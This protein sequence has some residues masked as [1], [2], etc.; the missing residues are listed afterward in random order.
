MSNN[1]TGYNTQDEAAMGGFRNIMSDNHKN[2]FDEFAFYVIVAANR[3]QAEFHY[4]TPQKL[5][6]NGGEAKFTPGR[7]QI[8]RAYCHTHPKRIKDEEF[9][10]DDAREFSK[11]IKIHPF[12]AW[13]LLTPTEQIR[14]A[15]TEA[16]FKA[17]KSITWIS[18]VQP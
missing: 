2:T 12:L 7:G 3:G 9:G 11:K 14:F 1:S 10:S 5:G 4:T 6:P 18:S 17:S 15:K 13:Y 8:L 16:D